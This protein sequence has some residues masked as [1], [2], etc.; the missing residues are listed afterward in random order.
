M[1]ITI[2]G[3]GLAGILAGGVV[4]W[5][6]TKNRLSEELDKSRG[7]AENYRIRFEDALSEQEQVK[8]ELTGE[9]EKV[10]DLNR[11]LSASEANYRNLEERLKQQK[12][13]LENI[14]EKFSHEFKNLANQIFEEKSKKFTEQNRSN[15]GDLLNPLKERIEKF[16]EKVERNSKESI[17]WNTALKEQLNHLK[18]LNQQVT[19]E[20]VNLTKALRGDSKTQGGWGEMQ[21]EAIL[22]KTGLEKDIHY[23]TE[24]NFK[25][26]DGRNQRLDFI[27]RLPDE[28]YLVLDS[29]VSLTAYAQ[30]FDTE[31]EATQKDCLQRHMLSINSHIKLLSAKNYQNLYD[32]NQPDYVMMFIANEPALTIALKEDPNLY[33]KALENNIVLVSTSTLMATLR[34]ISYI[35]KQ[36]LQNKNALEIARQAGSLYDKFTSFTDDLVKVGKNLEQTQGTYREAMKKLSE[37][38]GNLVRKAEKLRELGAKTSKNMDNRLIDRAGDE[39]NDDEE[40]DN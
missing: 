8:K 25:N 34:T 29:K 16:E 10:L 28:K 22:S 13:E 11:E 4:A 35:W 33:E 12:E 32:I 18:D 23:F 27:I 40:D 5:L 38:R 37:G 1:D 14:R 20:A 6:W 39:E 21:L 31:D 36:D 26:E 7:A 9:R 24:K 2:I 19:R 3:V 17:Q 30:Y 15:I